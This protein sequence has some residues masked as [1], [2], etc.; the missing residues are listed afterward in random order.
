MAINKLSLSKDEFI[1]T[2]WY[3]EEITIPNFIKNI[4]KN[5]TADDFFNKLISTIYQTCDLFI[6]QKMS[7]L[8]DSKMTIEEITK[9][10]GE[11]RL[12]NFRNAIYYEIRYR[13]ATQKFPEF[14]GKQRIITSAFSIA[15]DG[16]EFNKF[17]DLLCP[18]SISFLSNPT[19]SNLDIKSNSSDIL[20]VLKIFAETDE[21]II[22]KLDGFK[23]K[24]ST[25]DIGLDNA[26]TQQRINLKTSLDKATFYLTNRKTGEAV[27]IQPHS[28]SIWENFQDSGGNS[29]LAIYNIENYEKWNIASEQIKNL[30]TEGLN[31]LY[32]SI[33][34][35]GK[36]ESSRFGSESKLTNYGL[37]IKTKNGPTDFDIATFNVEHF[38]KVSEV[39][40]DV[41]NLKKNWIIKKSDFF[42][43]VK[44]NAELLENPKNYPNNILEINEKCKYI[45]LKE[46]NTSKY[47]IGDINFLNNT[48][49]EKF[50][51]SIYIYHSEVFYIKAQESFNY[52]ETKYYL[53]KND[54]TISIYMKKGDSKT[55]PHLFKFNE[56]EAGYELLAKIKI[57]IT[58]LY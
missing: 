13:L 21:K 19:W 4:N 41:E 34:T 23:E 6:N 40:K 49:G 28:V 36:D 47:Y 50:S 46:A 9:I 54:E 48:Y 55:N 18:E 11:K 1:N 16:R 39:I 56:T 45:I 30:H 38:K 32:K 29:K 3:E 35:I 15:N 44:V 10:I 8:L 14:S 31:L 5:I 2:Y 58:N 22:N 53:N 17:S 20:E 42:G 52:K 57:T 12:D 7:E 43:I 37:E 24:I 33:I 26:E 51:L 25:K 27:L